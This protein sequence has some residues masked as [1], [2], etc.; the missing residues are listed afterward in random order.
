MPKGSVRVFRGDS[1]AIG[2]ETFISIISS[3]FSSEDE[4][5]FI[6]SVVVFVFTFFRAARDADAREV[7]RTL[8]EK[9]KKKKTK[10]KTDKEEEDEKKRNSNA[11]T[12][13][14]NTNPFVKTLERRR[15]EDVLRENF[16]EN[17]NTTASSATTT[18]TSAAYRRLNNN[19]N[20]NGK[21]LDANV[22]CILDA[23]EASL[24]TRDSST[25]G[26]FTRE[27]RFLLLVFVYARHKLTVGKVADESKR[28]VVLELRRRELRG[29]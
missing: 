8:R 14:E 25:A 6:S 24:D 4:R 23:Y 20:N 15:V 12:T 27:S 21:K 9:E 28:G 7:V 11:N 16:E 26:G 29:G 3:S 19:N 18:T 22:K 17:N 13:T 5:Q 10:K 1:F 2:R